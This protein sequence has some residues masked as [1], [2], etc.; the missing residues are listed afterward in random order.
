[1]NDADRSDGKAVGEPISFTFQCPPDPSLNEL[2][3]LYQAFFSA[4][5]AEVELQQTEQAAW[6]Q[7]MLARDYEA[8]C[9]RVGADRDPYIVFSQAFQENPLNMTA[10][11]SPQIDEQLE[12]LKT[13]TDIDAR[14]AAVEA[15]GE[16][17][18]ENVPNT[19]TAGTLRVM[20]TRDA[21][22]NLDGWVFPDG[23]A[24]NGASNSQVMWGHVWVTD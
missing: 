3:Q 21:V 15:I 9:T 8:G 16:V 7:D 22:K 14:K 17:I 23:T 1:M 5:G 12:I 6:S 4:L 2:S 11:Q 18:D 24:G 10:F 13:T 19:F 20:G